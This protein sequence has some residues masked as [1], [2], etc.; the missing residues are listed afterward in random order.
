MSHL[1]K[2]KAKY[3]PVT[4]AEEMA[5][6]IC[7]DDLRRYYRFRPARFYG[8]IA[9]ADCLGCCL[10]CKFCWSW[11]EVVNPEHYGSFY[12]PRQVAANLTGIAR[13][14]RFRQLRISGNEPTIA[15]DHLLEVL[16]LVPEDLLFI[17]ETNGIM[18]GHDRTYAEDLARHENMYVRVS[19]KGSNENEFSLLRV[20]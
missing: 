2:R 7:K 4:R 11:R 18:I 19:F 16:N 6:L 17:L 14:K 12:S 1:P 10:Q 15:R 9:T 13:K 3:D 5:G 20:C 8:G